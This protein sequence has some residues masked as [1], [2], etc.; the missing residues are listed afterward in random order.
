MAKR[1]GEERAV[2][3]LIQV[4]GVT[5]DLLGCEGGNKRDGGNLHHIELFW[6]GELDLWS[7]DSRMRNRTNRCIM[8][9]PG[10]SRAHRERRGSA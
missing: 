9:R 7:A 5:S 10:G 3:E 4:L 8:Q 6:D 1:L 2:R